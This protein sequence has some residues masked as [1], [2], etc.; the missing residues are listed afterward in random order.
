[1][2]VKASI[3]NGATI[4]VFAAL[5]FGAAGRFDWPAA[6]AF[7]LLFF[8][9]SQVTVLRLARRDPALLAERLKPPV[10][11]GQPLWDKIF[12]LALASL[13]VGWLV[14]MGLDARFGWSAA[15]IWLRVVGAI[16]FV[17]GYWIIIRVFDEN[18]FLAPVV[19]IQRQRGHHVVS[20]GPYAVVRHPMYSGMCVMV[21]SAALLLGSW[22][23]LMFSLVIIAAGA[24][25]AIMEERELRTGLAGYADYAARVRYRLVPRVW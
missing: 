10:Q 4:L 5:L 25:R 15:P 18:T 2:I 24:W 22:I 17:A 3:A 9:L 1:M 14:V 21:P 8:A 13:W 23:G 12:I 16:G 6:W 19:K 7:V 11:R 20:T